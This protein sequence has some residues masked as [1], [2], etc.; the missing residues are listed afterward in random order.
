MNKIIFFLL[1]ILTGCIHSGGKHTGTT[2]KP[3]LFS[4]KKFQGNWLIKDYFDKLNSGTYVGSLSTAGYGLT[5]IRI[6]SA[7]H[8]S[9]WLFNEDDYSIRVPFKV[10]G[11]DSILVKMN[12]NDSSCISFMEKTGILNV[13]SYTHKRNFGYFHAPDSLLSDTYPKSTFRM[14]LNC[15]IARTSYVVYDPKVHP[16]HSTSAS[17]DCLGNIKGLKNFKTFRIYVNEALSNCRD[18][19]RIDFSDGKKTSSFGLVLVRNGIFLYQLVAY[20][21]YTGKPYFQRGN[22]LLEL[23]RPFR[24]SQSHKVT[25]SQRKNSGSISVVLCASSVNLSVIK[26]FQEHSTFPSAT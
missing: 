19:D 7:H 11:D 4:F 24:K 8:D 21:K 17:F 15:F 18:V 22:F 20:A 6:D 23:D 26:R 14:V 9:L 10:I 5:E 3:H 2:L 16:F 25:A 1:V 12:P 13:K